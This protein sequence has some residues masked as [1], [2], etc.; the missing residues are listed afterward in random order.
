MSAGQIR[1]LTDLQRQERAFRYGVGN[2]PA[3]NHVCHVLQMTLMGATWEFPRGNGL[4]LGVFNAQDVIGVL[5]AS[6]FDLACGAY[7]PEQSVLAGT[8]HHHII[9]CVHDHPD[10]AP[11]LSICHCRRLHLHA[12]PIGT[13]T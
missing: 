5:P 1:S 12:I 10:A 2:L 8:V 7:Q 6:E 3:V 9:A 4:S 13:G 11:G